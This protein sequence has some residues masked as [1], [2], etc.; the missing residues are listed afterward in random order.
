M[1][2]Y[3]AARAIRACD[4]IGCV[5]DLKQFGEFAIVGSTSI[6]SDNSGWRRFCEIKGSCTLL[7]LLLFV[8]ESDPASA[9]G[10]FETFFRRQIVL[11]FCNLTVRS[12][13]G[14]DTSYRD[15]E[16]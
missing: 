2:R 10:R 7:V 13:G 4:I 15:T 16:L 14:S 11:I 9:L 8:D 12:E 3:R 1:A 5:Q 6:S